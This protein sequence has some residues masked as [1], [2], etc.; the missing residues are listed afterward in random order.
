MMHHVKGQYASNLKKF[1][2][3]PTNQG[4][5][6][7]VPASLGKWINKNSPNATCPERRNGIKH[8]DTFLC[9]TYI[10][11]QH[12]ETP[13]EKNDWERNEFSTRNKTQY[14]LII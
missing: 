6:L 14:K 8:N 12:K 4:C 9:S 13:Q 2:K 1:T 7:H 3:K 10:Q 11:M 5:A